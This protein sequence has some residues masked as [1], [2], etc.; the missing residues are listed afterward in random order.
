MQRKLLTRSYCRCRLSIFFHFMC[1]F[2]PV[3]L[4][5]QQQEAAAPD[6][7]SL[8]QIRTVRLRPLSILL[9]L[10]VQNAPVMRANAVAVAQNKAAHQI[11]KLSWTDALQANVGFQYGQGALLDA[12]NN[13]IGTTYLL[14]D[15]QN[16]GSNLGLTLR[17]SSGMFTLQPLRNRVAQLQV[18]R[19]KLEGDIQAK[20]IREEVITLYVQLES[21]LKMLKI[22]SEI[23]ENQR[24]SMA[25]AD[26]YFREGNMSVTDYNALLNQ[27]STVEENLE[28]IRADT[29]RLHL[30]LREMVSA[31]VFENTPTKPAKTING[32]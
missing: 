14:S 13:G 4:V 1:F 27:L 2:M 22:K 17:I 28:K 21:A 5:G 16:F 31:P 10:A 32:K 3:A 23:L 8:A 24:L 12:T 26:K 7:D 29:K 11:Q 25:V 19:F 20:G 6:L 15:R 18:E 30:L 9:D